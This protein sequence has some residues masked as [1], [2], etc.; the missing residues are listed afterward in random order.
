VEGAPDGCLWLNADGQIIYANKAAEKLLGMNR[1]QLS[2]RTQAHIFPEL[3]SAV[4]QRLVTGEL[5]DVIEDTQ[6]VRGDGSRVA[7]QILARHFTLQGELYSCVYMRDLT[8]EKLLERRLLEAHRTEAL[9]RLAGGVAHD[10]NN[11]LTGVLLYADLLAPQLRRRADA[12][13]YLNE[14]R[15]IGA[16]GSQLVN[17]LL[18]YS[19]PQ[20][21]QMKIVSVNSVI[22]GM[23]DLLRRL[24]G[25][26]IE[27][28]T[29]C[30]EPLGDVK[31]DRAQMEQVILNLA[32]NARE[33]MP[34]G[35]KL[36]METLPIDIDGSQAAMSRQDLRP[37]RYV[38]L[39]VTDTGYGMDK[40][41]QQRIFEP[42]F[43]T[44]ESGKNWGLGLAT[45]YSIIRQAGGTIDVESS[46]GRG[47]R[48]SV[49]LPMIESEPEPEGARPTRSGEDAPRPTVLLVE[50]DRAVRT[51][52][53]QLLERAGVKV[54]AAADAREA[55]RISRVHPGKLDLLIADF[56]VPGIPGDDW[57]KEVLSQRPGL[58]VLYISD[59]AEARQ[60][61]KASG[62]AVLYRPFDGAI[63]AKEVTAALGLANKRK[64]RMRS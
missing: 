49:L 53:Q 36:V 32:V 30:A 10:F 44:R 34:I 27:L 5:G 48:F 57:V 1:E 28:V 40:E 15:G 16:R 59:H 6:C 55:V 45:A 25:D 29:R 26:D 7:V 3:R 11:L 19:Q 52:S 39:A 42:Y 23:R 20:L 2:M 35:G 14:L 37:G 60:P 58:Q 31:I 64:I 38:Q 50:D 17:R 43:S 54:L 47:S 41:T 4:L 13:R 51:S 8:H 61:E 24:L 56:V 18:D 21:P 9:G 62:A 12:H 46:P 33:A 63:L 22:E